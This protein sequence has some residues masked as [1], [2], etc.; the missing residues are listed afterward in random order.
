MSSECFVCCEKFDL[1]NKS[2]I[3][4]P[5]PSCLYE[6]C[7]A[8]VRNYLVNTVN[9]VHCMKCK[10]AWDQTFVI[11]N[12]NRSW[13]QSHY[14]THR[15]ELLFQSEHSKFPETM[16]FVEQYK[17]IIDI[18]KEKNIKKKKIQ[19]LQNE[20]YELHRENNVLDRKIRIIKTGKEEVERQKFIM[21]CQKEDCK[22]FLSSGYKCG[23]CDEFCCAQCLEMIG[24][25]KNVEHKCN[26][27][28]IETAK[29]IKKT[30]KPCPT[31]GE[32]IHKIDGCDQMWCT[33]CHT[34]FS[35]KTGEVQN[36]TIHNPHYFHY[37]RDVNNGN[38]PRQPGDN[39]CM[40][41]LPI[42]SFIINSI[43]NILYDGKYLKLDAVNT[44][45]AHRIN[46]HV[47]SKKIYFKECK[48][49]EWKETPYIWFHIDAEYITSS[50]RKFRHIQHVEIPACQQIIN[51]A[52]ECR[53]LRIDYIMNIIDK[54]EFQNKLM[55]KDRQRKQNTDL[56][57]LYDLIR[58]VGIDTINKIFGVIDNQL[59]LSRDEIMMILKS[60]PMDELLD[61]FATCKDEIEKFTE[62]CNKQL[63][64][65]GV[66]HDSSVRSIESVLQ[67]TWVSFRHIKSKHNNTSDLSGY[68]VIPTCD[69][70]R[71]RKKTM[72]HIKEYYAKS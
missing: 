23:L 53:Q 34:A 37:M 22:G 49:D 54:D 30:T 47:N 15:N 7:K 13:H 31:C 17:K 18:E 61:T 4:C 36:G 35:W 28:N 2:K 19:E 21:P 63:D 59:H 57:Y 12:L 41:S 55:Q 3:T 16:P 52:T 20:I 71:K 1:K 56:L 68:I 58:T 62:Y 32:R 45:H 42:L 9:D 67:R 46:A 40:D 8:C 64:I 27:A 26:E 65:I 43:S 44:A 69:F 51:D 25:D 38:I 60:K 11:L 39:P 70:S 6:C 72:K 10:Q 33:T 29:F 66:S 24:P 50:L 5:N 14:T 48:D